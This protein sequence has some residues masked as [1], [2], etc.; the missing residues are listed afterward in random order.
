[1]A[2]RPGW[3]ALAEFLG[4][5][6][7]PP[8]PSP[9]LMAEVEAPVPAGTTQASI[10]GPPPTQVAQAGISG[11]A[12]QTG[13]RKMDRGMALSPPGSLLPGD[14]AHA[15]AT[16]GLMVPPDY[17]WPPRPAPGN[18][19]I[20][21]ELR[22]IA[23]EKRADFLHYDPLFGTVQKLR[24]YHVGLYRMSGVGPGTRRALDTFMSWEIAGVP[25]YSDPR[26]PNNERPAVSG[27][28]P[29]TLDSLVKQNLM[30]NLKPDTKPMDLE[31][32]QWPQVHVA[33]LNDSL[34]LVDGIQALERM[35]PGVAAATGDAI[36]RLGQGTG[37]RIIQRSVEAVRQARRERGIKIE[38]LVADGQFG[39][40]TLEA[41]IDATQT[42][43]DAEI[44]RAWYLREREAELPRESRRNEYTSSLIVDRWRQ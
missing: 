28:S 8:R 33:T 25:D 37:V 24:D 36:L 5:S 38:E 39:E 23:P 13:T 35:P 1:M 44:F 20:D 10:Q 21:E 18:R 4:L 15:G 26:D 32:W 22:F 40:K 12:K 19:P 2:P 30:P 34:R 43:K 6:P 17:E 3:A 16:G 31:P 29:H 7:A 11:T 9:W 14:P 27:I 42:P 41:I